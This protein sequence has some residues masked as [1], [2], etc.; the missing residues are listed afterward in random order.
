MGRRL[1]NQENAMKCIICRHGETAA[2]LVTV[3]LQ[4]GESTIIFK[5]VPADVCENCGEYYLSQAVTDGLLA[6]AEEAVKNGAEV[7]ILR[8]A[9]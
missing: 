2:G 5:G 3:S 4:R 8:F 6:R 7:E 9:A 1:Q